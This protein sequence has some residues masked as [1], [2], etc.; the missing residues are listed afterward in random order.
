MSVR[1]KAVCTETESTD[2]DLVLN[3]SAT[4]KTLSVVLGLENQVR[5]TGALEEGYKPHQ[6][7]IDF[8]RF[9]GFPSLRDD[10]E[11]LAFLVEKTILDRQPGRVKFQRRGHDLTETQYACKPV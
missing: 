9:V 8:V 5:A 6:G 3:V 10:D 7:N 11:N 2:A 1:I 4:G